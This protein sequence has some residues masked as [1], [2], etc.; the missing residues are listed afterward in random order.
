M[1]QPTKTI[2]LRTTNCRSSPAPTPPPSPFN[3]ILLRKIA[4]YSLLSCSHKRLHIF[5]THGPDTKNPLRL[6]L[7]NLDGSKICTRLP[8]LSSMLQHRDVRE[9]RKIV[10]YLIRRRIFASLQNI[11]RSISRGGISGRGF[12]WGSLR[13]DFGKMEDMMR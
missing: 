8:H 10:P 12:F 9:D 13:S 3:Q 4:S 1:R 6:W 7:S 5:N 2:F 11:S